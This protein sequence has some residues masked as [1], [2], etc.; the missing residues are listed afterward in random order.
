MN[1]LPGIKIIKDGGLWKKISEQIYHPTIEELYWYYSGTH[2]GLDP[3]NP[4]SLHRT[5]TTRV[6]YKKASIK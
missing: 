2:A 1:K 3:K 6:V 4:Y 5:N